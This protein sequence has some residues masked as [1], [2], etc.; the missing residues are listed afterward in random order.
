MLVYTELFALRLYCKCIAFDVV[1]LKALPNKRPVRSRKDVAAE[2]GKDRTLSPIPNGK[3][4]M[5][6]KLKVNKCA[7]LQQ[8]KLWERSLKGW[9]LHFTKRHTKPSVKGRTE[10]LVGKSVAPN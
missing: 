9:Q 5:A 2:L 6:T 3:E 4:K 8:P 7:R 1:I 10:E